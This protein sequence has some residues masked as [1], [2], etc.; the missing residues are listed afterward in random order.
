MDLKKL[1]ERVYE[2]RKLTANVTDETTL[3]GYH[4]DSLDN[5][6]WVI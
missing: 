2:A 3:L 5:S 6:T 4:R 1:T